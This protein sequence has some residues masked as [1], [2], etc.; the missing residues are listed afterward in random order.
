MNVTG[1][2]ET[3]SCGKAGSIRPSVCRVKRFLPSLLSTV[4][5]PI[6]CGRCTVPGDVQGQ[7]GCGSEQPDSMV[8]DGC[9]GD[10]LI[11]LHQPFWQLFLE[12]VILDDEF[13]MMTSA[14]HRRS[15]AFVLV[16]RSWL[17]QKAKSGALGLH[18]NLCL[19]S[20][21]GF[22]QNLQP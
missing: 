8:C 6:I 1:S 3:W 11:F 14:P 22:L 9:S 2:L 20:F 7:G 12:L 16:G 4:L 21:V 15:V 10:Q 13:W 5:L 18:R 19:L 17:L